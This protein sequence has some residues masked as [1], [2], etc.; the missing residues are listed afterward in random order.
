MVILMCYVDDNI[1][2]NFG[3]DCILRIVMAFASSINFS[4]T[5]VEYYLIKMVEV[6]WRFDEH[7]QTD[8]ISS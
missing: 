6:E 4:K 7:E 5:L 8:V 1:Y 3:V 2:L